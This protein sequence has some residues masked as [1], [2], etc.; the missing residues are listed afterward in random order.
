[1]TA[2]P[3]KDKPTKKKPTVKPDYHGERQLRHVF[4]EKETIEIAKKMAEASRDLNQAE[5]EKKAVTSTLKAK[6][7]GIQARVNEHAGKINSGFE[8]RTTPIT[9]KFHTPKTGQKQTARDDTG[10]IIE[11]DQMSMAEMQDELPLGTVEPFNPAMTEENSKR[12]KA[13]PGVVSVPAD[14]DG[15]DLVE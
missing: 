5:E 7:D 2:K 12:I 4:S 10:E 3:K 11:T 15:K 8:Y 9:V 13:N 6:V 14:G 1:M